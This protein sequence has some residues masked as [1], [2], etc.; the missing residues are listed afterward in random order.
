M[1][2]QI[3]RYAGIGSAPYGD[4]VIVRES[5]GPNIL[6]MWVSAL[7][8]S[9]YTLQSAPW[10]PTYE[11]GWVHWPGNDGRMQTAELGQYEIPTRETADHLAKLYAV[12][13]KPLHVLEYPF[14][15]G[16]PAASASL[17]RLLQW[18]NL[19]TLPVWQ[20]A[21]YYTLNAEDIHPHVADGLC[22][23]LIARIYP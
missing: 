16:G 1:A 3:F 2:D 13:G 10:V 7:S 14:I 12:D 8:N 4:P 18:P 22:K 23:L 5:W 20:L 15:S 17:V 6:Q 21:V 19:Q 9:G 11:E